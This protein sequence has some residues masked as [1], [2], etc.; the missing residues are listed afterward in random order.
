MAVQISLA[1]LL[2]LQEFPVFIALGHLTQA[3]NDTASFFSTSA[4]F[5]SASAIFFLIVIAFVGPVFQRV[6]LQFMAQFR[7]FFR[8]LGDEPNMSLRLVIDLFILLE[9]TEFQ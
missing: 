9:L 8:I 5:F 7:Q 6:Y 2:G 3:F 4:S 1:V